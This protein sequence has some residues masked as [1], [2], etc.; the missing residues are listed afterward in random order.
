[1]NRR[2]SG[3]SGELIRDRT[4]VFLGLVTIVA[5]TA[6][7]FDTVRNS[8]IVYCAHDSVFADG[9]LRE[10]EKRSGI[11]VLAR[12][13]TE[14][15]KS[16]GLTELIIREKDAPRCDVFWNN[17]MLGT[18]DLAERGLLEPYRGPGWQRIPEMWKDLDGRW[19][20]FAGRMRVTIINSKAVAAAA[21]DPTFARGSL[22]NVAI[23][24]P[25]YGTTLTH[26]TVLWHQWGEDRLRAWHRE[27]RHRGLREVNGNGAVKQI[28]A[29]GTC[30]YG[31]TDTDDFF[32]AKDSG[33]PVRMTPVVLD[34]GATI[35]IPNTAG[36][37]RG[38]HHL[39]QAQKFVDFLLSGESEV[40]LA[41]SKARQIPLG[42]GVAEGS[43]PAEV[44]ELEALVPK[45]TPLAGLLQARAE[46]LAWLKLEYSE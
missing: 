7:R 28:V 34:D 18:M 9:V 3:S 21:P 11:K 33:A 23:A 38:T 36:I 46:C 17:E 39:S 1:M 14:A 30:D 19:A 6:W 45:A 25:L 35:C 15:T 27:T 41:R 44:K 13:D 22:E 20:G 16:L 32:D 4:L 43:I 26:Y 5:L 24:K 8:I 10:F 40:A 2:G 42:S 29:Q 37:I 31:L 12:Y